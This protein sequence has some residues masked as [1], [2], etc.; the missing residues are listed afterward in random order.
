MTDDAPRAGRRASEQTRT[1][2]V[3][4]A[5]RLWAQ[6]GVDAVSLRDVNRAAGQRNTNALHYHFGDRATLLTAVLAPHDAQVELARHALLDRCEAAGASD[7][8]ALAAALVE[9][10]AHRLGVAGGQHFLM[11]RAQLVAGPDPLVEPEHRSDPTHSVHRWRALLDPLLSD[12]ARTLHHRFTARRLTL[13]ELGFR[14]AR[15]SRADDALFTSNL[16]DL[17]AALLSVQPS[18]QTQQ[19]LRPGPSGR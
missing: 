11:I 3:D 9:P 17:V 6:R 10:L 2:L 14:A 7:V 19:R 4:T 8:R 15:S 5:A 12:A 1:L 13:L 18:E 16:V